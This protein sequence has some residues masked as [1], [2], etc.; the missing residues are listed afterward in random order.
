ML[1]S[2]GNMATYWLSGFSSSMA[3]Y[4]LNPNHVNRAVD[5]HKI[6]GKVEDVI[7]DLLVPLFIGG[8]AGSGM[9]ALAAIALA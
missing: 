5:L 9:A 7:L 4:I 3:W 6:A 1:L 8:S 2:R